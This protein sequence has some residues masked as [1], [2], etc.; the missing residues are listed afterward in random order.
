MCEAAEAY[1]TLR[2]AIHFGASG[3]IK[4]VLITSPTPGDG[5]STIASNLAISMAQA[6]HRTLL[7][8]A[9]MRRPMQ[10]NVFGLTPALGLSAVLGDGGNLNDLALATNIEKLSLLA[11]GAIPRNPSELLSSARFAAVLR[12]AREHFD[13]IVI[14][15]PPV[16]PVADAKIV[17]ASVDAVLLVVRIDKSNRKASALA[18]EGLRS[19]GANVFGWVAND[20]SAASQATYGGYY[21]NYYGNGELHTPVVPAIKAA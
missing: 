14:D 1:R 17:S 18:L 7:I 2:T 5:K 6:G 21:G 10:H 16:L 9:D 19:V 11:C 3:E 4:T 15:S 8:D 13:R 12:G 20:M